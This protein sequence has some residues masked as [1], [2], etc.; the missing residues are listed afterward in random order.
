Q[1]HLTPLAPTYA[2]YPA[3]RSP[4]HRL[5]LAVPGRVGAVVHCR[6]RTEYRIGGGDDDRERGVPRLPQP[7]ARH[8]GRQRHAGGDRRRPH[9]VRGRAGRQHARGRDDGVPRIPQEDPQADGAVGREPADV[10]PPAPGEG[11]AAGY[12]GMP[13]TAKERNLAYLSPIFRGSLNSAELRQALIFS[14]LSQTCTA[15][16]D[17]GGAPSNAVVLL[18][19]A[20]R[21]PPAAL[22]PA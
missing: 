19:A 6:D 1:D 14:T 10:R 11:V 7:L 3:S 4:P 20:T 15:T 17:F 12:C 13:S 16:R 18:P 5:R 9:L 8:R 2:A 21:R 22:I